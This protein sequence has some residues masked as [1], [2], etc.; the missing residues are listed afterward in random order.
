MVNP[1][2][3]FIL[4]AASEEAQGVASCRRFV[5]GDSR[6]S[7]HTCVSIPLVCVYLIGGF[8]RNN[9]E[10]NVEKEDLPSFC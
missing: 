5:H 7:R 8:N 2:R 1:S 4:G 9:V 10:L 6:T 3:V